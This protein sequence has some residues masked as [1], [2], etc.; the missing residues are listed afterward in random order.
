MADLVLHVDGAEDAA[1]TVDRFALRERVSEPF[2]LSIVVGSTRPDLNLEELILRPASFV[3]DAGRVH[4]RRVYTGLCFAAEQ[5]SAEP[6]GLSLYRIRILPRLGLLALRRDHRIYQQ[7]TIP[8]ILG[9]MLAAYLIPA[10][11][12]LDENAF[13]VLDFKVQYLVMELLAGHDLAVELERSGRFDVARAVTL[14]LE[15]CEGVADAHAVGLGHRDLEPANLFL[16]HRDNRPPVVKVL[17]FGLSKEPRQDESVALTQDGS[18]FGTP[19][20]MSPEQ[21]ISTKGRR[22]AQRS[23]RA[24]DDPLRGAHRPHTVRGHDGEPAPIACRMA[25]RPTSTAVESAPRA[26]SAR[27]ARTTASA[28]ARAASRGS[29]SWAARESPAPAPRIA[30]APSASPGA[31]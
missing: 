24:G 10:A 5:M 18:I 16:A 3:I 14:V 2:S 11:F 30:P 21:V 22:R 7:L 29:A 19:P 15:A 25:T 20:Y 13:P 6:G 23:A 12:H 31:A 9:Q 27:S 28:G 17:D 1:L 26:A 4:G 8:A